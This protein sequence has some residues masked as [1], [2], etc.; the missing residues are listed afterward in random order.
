MA[1]GQI[2]LTI[3]GEDMKGKHVQ[4][5]MDELHVRHAHPHRASAH[6]HSKHGLEFESLLTCVCLAQHADRPMKLGLKPGSMEL[7]LLAYQDHLH[8]PGKKEKKSK[9]K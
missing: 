5:V 6:N 8:R 2:I 4:E 9:K 3:N 7:Q 1:R